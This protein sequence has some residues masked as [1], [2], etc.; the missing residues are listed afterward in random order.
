MDAEAMFPEGFHPV[1]VA[2]KRDYSGEATW[3]SRSTVGMRYYF[4]GFGRSM[5]IPEALPEGAVTRSHGYDQ[6]A[7][8][9]SDTFPYNPFTKDVFIIGKMFKREF[10]KVIVPRPVT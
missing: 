9:L 6:E 7:P 2:L 3:V 10:C 8:E 1:H 4:T 5:H